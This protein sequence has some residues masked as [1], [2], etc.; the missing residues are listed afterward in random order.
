MGLATVPA[1][2]QEE[3]DPTVQEK[4]EDKPEK[5]EPRS[6]EEER[7]AGPQ[8]EEEPD[9]YSIIE[10]NDGPPREVIEQWKQEFREVH[11]LPINDDNLFLYRS[12]NRAEH[13]RFK[14]VF[15]QAGEGLTEDMRKE[16]IV[17]HCLLSPRIPEGQFDL[18]PAGLV[19]TLY[20]AV[21]FSSMFLQPQMVMGLIMRL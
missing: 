13:N 21:S 7:T 19:D 9:I 20:E 18:H 11:L 15:A 2:V 1:P 4:G 10:A 8:F 12:L 6:P 3:D 5:E 14:A 16:K 17:A